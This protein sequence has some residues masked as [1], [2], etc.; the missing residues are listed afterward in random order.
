MSEERRQPRL[1]PTEG[2]RERSN[3]SP[4]RE[5]T[6]SRDR[7][8]AR[9][10]EPTRHEDARLAPA[11]GDTPSQVGKALEAKLAEGPEGGQPVQSDLDRAREHAR[12]GRGDVPFIGWRGEETDVDGA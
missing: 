2:S 9:R 5:G 12:D 3:E 4:G 10:Q 6:G 7:K 11:P 8:V 1:T